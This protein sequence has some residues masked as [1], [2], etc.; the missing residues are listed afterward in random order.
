MEEGDE[1]AKN[2]ADANKGTVVANATAQSTD[3]ISVGLNV[4][5]SG[6]AE[7]RNERLDNCDVWKA[8]ELIQLQ[9]NEKIRNQELRNKELEE[10][11][12]AR[13]KTYE[14]KVEEM[15]TEKISELRNNDRAKIYKFDASN[16]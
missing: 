1:D 5:P 7:E 10:K 11:M 15:R 9:M 8:I 13:N 3:E 6:L 2:V 12:E 16:A 4:D 14:E